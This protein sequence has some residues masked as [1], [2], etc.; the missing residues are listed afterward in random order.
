MVPHAENLSNS[1]FLPI[2]FINYFRGFQKCPSLIKPKGLVELMA[3]VM[4]ISPN[5]LAVLRAFGGCLH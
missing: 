1:P 3:N 5:V 4:S 2:S